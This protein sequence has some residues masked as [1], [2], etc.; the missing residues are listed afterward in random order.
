M[1]G[2]SEKEGVFLVT[3][4]DDGTS[5][6]RDVNTGQVHTIEG[7]PDVEVWDVVEATITIVPPLAVTWR[8]AST[9]NHRSLTVVE[10]DESPTTRARKLAGDL[11]TGEVTREPRAGNGAVHVLSVPP[12]ETEAKVGDVIGVET[13]TRAARMGVERVEV[14]AEDGIVSVRYLP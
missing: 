10:S 3:A 8:L 14:R 11:A 1:S 13:M 9:E 2:R 12:A 6:M 7:N 5:V 4:V